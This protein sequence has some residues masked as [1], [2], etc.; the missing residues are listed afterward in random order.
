MASNGPGKYFLANNL[1]FIVVSEK[2]GKAKA[3]I[4]FRLTLAKKGKN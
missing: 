4:C 2:N 3:E 1:V